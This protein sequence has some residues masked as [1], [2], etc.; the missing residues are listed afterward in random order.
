MSSLKAGF[1]IGLLSLGLF[2][3]SEPEPQV[4]DL[5]EVAAEAGLSEDEYKVHDD[6]AIEVKSKAKDRA[7][8]NA[9]DPLAMQGENWQYV[10]SNALLVA[11][12]HAVKNNPSAVYLPQ[13]S[14]ISL[15]EQMAGEY[16]GEHLLTVVNDNHGDI[17]Y[18]QLRPLF[19]VNESSDLL[20]EQL[21][22][23]TPLWEVTVAKYN[24]QEF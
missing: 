1:Y 11:D 7:V 13:S 17:S 21:N 2:G 10:V 12:A 22:D 8:V 18:V 16:Q 19:D 23:E 14:D 6:G 4:I 9:N 15:I 3:C 20:E 24:G 5:D